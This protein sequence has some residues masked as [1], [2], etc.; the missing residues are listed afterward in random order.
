MRYSLSD[1]WQAFLDMIIRFFENRFQNRENEIVSLLKIE[2]ERE[3]QHSS[4]LLVVIQ[5]LAAPKPIEVEP[6]EDIEH[7]PIGRV[8]WHV[9][10]RELEI[11]ARK[12]RQEM[13]REA[14]EA[15]NK[16]KVVVSN[17][18]PQ[19]VDELETEL[20]ITNNGL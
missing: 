13:D 15:I 16:N 17:P 6:Q 8:P 1:V 4:K 9:K 3:R 5:D 18:N 10:A 12:K 19:T 20:G 14:Q 7:K 2:L 11:A